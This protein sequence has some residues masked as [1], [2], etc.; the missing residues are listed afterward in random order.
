MKLILRDLATPNLGGL[1]NPLN[2]HPKTD[3]PILQ[4]SKEKP[5][6]PSLC[7]G[8]IIDDKLT[9]VEGRKGESRFDFTNGD[10]LEH[11]KEE[12]DSRFNIASSTTENK[13][14]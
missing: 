6:L 11:S 8:G 1:E 2:G 10:Y 9:L 7:R 13:S 12:L 4:A 3:T 5:I 14:S